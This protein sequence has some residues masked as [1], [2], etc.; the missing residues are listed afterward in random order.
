[1]WWET[2][3]IYTYN[4]N[5]I[6]CNISLHLQDVHFKQIQLFS[7]IFTVYWNLIEIYSFAFAYNKPKSILQI[8][9]EII[10]EYKIHFCTLVAKR[11]NK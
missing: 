10:T 6:R 8:S 2:S 11:I 4:I 9:N 7:Y 1:M 3:S 5:T